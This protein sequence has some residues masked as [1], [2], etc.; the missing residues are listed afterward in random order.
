VSYELKVERVL[1]ATTEEVF[2]AFTDQEAMRQWF[3]GPDEPPGAVVEVTCDPR[4]GGEWI[5]V[6]GDDPEHLYR[7]RN[8]FRV[9]EPPRRLAMDTTMTTPDGRRLDTTVDI[10]IDG[11]DGKTR[12]TVVQRGFPDA[13]VR[14]Y[15]ATHA[16]VGALE[17]IQHHLTTRKDTR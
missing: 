16:W 8:V 4:V 3:H 15:F 2:E 11:V 17:R 1:D 14:D 9:V 13:A 6:W 7:E 12:V 5:A 10:R